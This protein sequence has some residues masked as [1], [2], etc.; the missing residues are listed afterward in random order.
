MCWEDVEIGEGTPFAA[1]SK[2]CTTAIVS[3]LAAR[4]PYRSVLTFTPCSVDSL[5]LMPDVDPTA[6]TGYL[7]TTAPEGMLELRLEVHGRIVQAEW[8]AIPSG[9][10]D[11][12]LFVVQA[13]NAGIDRKVGPNK[14]G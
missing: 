2:T 8:R 3:V 6:T 11:V 10:N 13:F 9:A 5:R 4:D 12:S 7:V 1:A 14:H